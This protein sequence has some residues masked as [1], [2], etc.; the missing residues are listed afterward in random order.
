M[1]G[2][3]LDAAFTNIVRSGSL[4]ATASSFPPLVVTTLV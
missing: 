2:R 1:A 4:S 3:H